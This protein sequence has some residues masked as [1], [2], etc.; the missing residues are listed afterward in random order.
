MQKL[1]RKGQVF[2]KRMHSKDALRRSVDE[3]VHLCTREIGR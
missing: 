3:I 2:D 1:S